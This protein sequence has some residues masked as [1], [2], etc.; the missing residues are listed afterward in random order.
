[1]FEDWPLT[2]NEIEFGFVSAVDA[3][4][5][6]GRVY[7]FKQYTLGAELYIDQERFPNA[8]SY[9]GKE[10]T[11]NSKPYTLVKAEFDRFVSAT[12]KEVGV[13]KAKQ[14]DLD[15]ADARR[16]LGLGDLVG[17][18]ALQ[19]EVADFGQSYVPRPEYEERTAGMSEKVVKKTE[20]RKAE[21]RAITG[22]QTAV[23]ELAAGN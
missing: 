21:E 7:H 19:I 12:R 13:V 2:E 1:M 11:R 20:A 23:A 5:G 22:L 9:R 3:T 17:L 15:G 6:I 14:E 18:G 10:L 8:W 16:E 4:S